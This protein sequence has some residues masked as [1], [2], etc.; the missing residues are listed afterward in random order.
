M[1]RFNLNG[2]ECLA[3]TDD[4]CESTVGN[5]K[6][7]YQAKQ[8]MIEVKLPKTHPYYG[9][10]PNSIL[11]EYHSLAAGPLSYKESIYEFTEWWIGIDV[12]CRNLEATEKELNK[13]AKEK[14]KEFTEALTLQ[15]VYSREAAYIGKLEKTIKTLERHLL[16]RL[17]PDELLYGNG[18]I[19]R[20]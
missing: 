1:N 11:E 3:F 6:E 2:F 5:D 9:R 12:Y 16:K 10:S 8:I 4:P 17:K 13:F 14:L 7:T 18:T 15:R 20:K 19:K